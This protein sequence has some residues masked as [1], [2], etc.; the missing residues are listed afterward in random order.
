M[1]ATQNTWKVGDI[2]YQAQIYRHGRGLDYDCPARETQAEAEAD[3]ADSL[4]M[5]SEREREQSE[6]ESHVGRYE[7]LDLAADGSIGSAIGR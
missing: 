3:L 2:Y 7:I 4:S 6:I 1:N 5:M